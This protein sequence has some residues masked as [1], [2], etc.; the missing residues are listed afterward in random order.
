MISRAFFREL[1]KVEFNEANF[2][3]RF[4][5]S[6]WSTLTAKLYPVTTETVI[7]SVAASDFHPSELICGASR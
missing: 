3:D 5:Q 2:S 6:A 1:A 4:L 7:R